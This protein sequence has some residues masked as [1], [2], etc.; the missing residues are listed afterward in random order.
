[1]G[2]RREREPRP[3]GAIG[4]RLRRAPE[5]GRRR[6]D[7]HRPE[8]HPRSGRERAPPRRVAG[9][10]RFGALPRLL[11][12]PRPAVLLPDGARGPMVHRG[13]RRLSGSTRR[14]GADGG[15][16]PPRGLPSGPA[17]LPGR[18]PRRG[19]RPCVE[20]TV[21]VRPDAPALVAWLAVILGLVRWR[22]ER[23]PRWL[24][25]SGLMLGAA[26]ALNLKA[27]YG[28]GAILLVVAMAKPGTD[29][30]PRT[31]AAV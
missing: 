13:C 2:P 12:S 4:R 14:H 27:V 21:E 16:Q 6:P 23:H 10:V 31:A 18:P 22:E 26:M 17:G 29:R 25:L 1:L 5:P 9:R 15:G 11:G 8:H 28:A 24:W 7:R 20:K 30:R 19:S 3:P